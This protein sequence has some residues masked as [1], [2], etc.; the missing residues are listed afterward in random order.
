MYSNLV[1]MIS[2]NGNGSRWW[3]AQ[4]SAGAIAN[5]GASQDQRPARLAR[6]LSRTTTKSFVPLAGR[7]QFSV[8]R[9]SRVA[10]PAAL[11]SRGGATFGLE[12]AHRGGWELF[13]LRRRANGT[14]VQFS[15]AVRA[16]AT[17]SC[18]DAVATECAFETTNHRLAGRRRQVLVAAFTIG[19]EHKHGLSPSLHGLNASLS[20]I[21]RFVNM[22]PTE[23]S[24]H[25]SDRYQTSTATA[26][27]NAF[28]SL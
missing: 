7:S 12:N 4:S 3:T 27:S 24:V 28:M 2:C 14:R 6:R 16:A 26:S 1:K 22:S 11:G 20:R 5:R 19:F 21:E 8:I 17:Q 25:H 18:F 15:A 13:K 9:S 10:E 23:C